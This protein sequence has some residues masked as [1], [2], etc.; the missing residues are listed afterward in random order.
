MLPEWT[1]QILRIIWAVLRITERNKLQGVRRG[2][3]AQ[4][5]E[6]GSIALEKRVVWRSYSSFLVH[7]YLLTHRSPSAANELM[8]ALWRDERA[9]R[10]SL[11]EDGDMLR[12][13]WGAARRGA[14][15]RFEID[16]TRQFI[17]TDSDEGTMWQLS[18][19]FPVLGGRGRLL[20]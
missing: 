19:A 1:C 3:G 17:E 15:A 10:C 11:A 7:C 6:P 9:K 18:L 12:F 20:E 2:L 13:Q 16:L 5:G 8:L 14:K 4:R